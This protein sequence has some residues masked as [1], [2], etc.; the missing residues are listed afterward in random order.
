M[1]FSDGNFS[2]RYWPGIGGGYLDDCTILADFRAVRGRDPRRKLPSIATYRARAITPW[3][4]A[5]VPDTDTASE[6]LSLEA[7]LAAIEATWPDLPAELYR[8]SWSGFASAVKSGAI[9]SASVLSRSLP[10]RHRYGFNLNHRVVFFWTGSGW[11]ILNPLA[12]PHSKPKSISEEEVRI[13]MRDYPS[14]EAACAI[15]VF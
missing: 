9:A 15:L 5:G 14:A 11:R 10:E 13:A 8:G 12:P 4:P 2:Q 1:D 6:G 7:S 3:T